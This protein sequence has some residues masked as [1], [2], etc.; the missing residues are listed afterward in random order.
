MKNWISRCMR[1]K[2]M[3]FNAIVASLAALEGVFSLLQPH[4]GGNVYAYLTIALTVGN[5]FLR[6][7]TTQ[8]LKDK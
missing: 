3:L 4:I 1:S 8:P 6:V 5:A 7:I 2:T